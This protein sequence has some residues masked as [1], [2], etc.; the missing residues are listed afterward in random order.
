M[1][2]DRFVSSWH[3]L[4]S[5]VTDTKVL[6]LQAFMNSNFHFFIMFQDETNTCICSEIMLKKYGY[7]SGINGLR[8]NFMA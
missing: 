7:F 2:T 8:L 6:R 3:E 1:H 4:N 5:I